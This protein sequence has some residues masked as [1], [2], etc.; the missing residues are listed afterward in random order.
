MEAVGQL[1]GGVAHDFN[2]LLAVILGNA[3][4]ALG[5][6]EISH[7]AEVI[8]SLRQVIAASQKAANLTRQLLAF[9]R[10]QVLNMVPL[11]LGLL[12][13]DLAKMLRRIIGEHIELNCECAPGLP[14]V[15]AD[16]GALEQVLMNLVVNARDAMPKGGI[17]TIGAMVRKLSGAENGRPAR[18]GT[19]ACLQV[20]DSGSG[21]AP[22][23]LPHI[24]E[25]FYTTKEIGKGTGL[26]LATVHGLMQQHN[27]WVEVKSQPGLGSTFSLFLPAIAA[28]AL[29]P[30]STAA[31]PGARGTETILLVEDDEAV[32]KLTSKILQRAGFTIHQSTSG[33]QALDQWKNAADGFDLL[34]TDILMPGGVSGVELAESLRERRP[35]LRVLYMSGYSG[36]QVGNLAAAPKSRRARLLRKPF[37]AADLVQAVRD[38]LDGLAHS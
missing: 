28:A 20:T 12:L 34:L 7:S 5:A 14:L 18:T 10:K 9:S 24:F 21:I 38:T 35:G 32:R 23:H 30:G 37:Q 22:E 17:L 11:D 8:D 36:D 27:G 15:L 29:Q 16:A 1:A 19:F 6:P 3:E 26:G 2:N 31:L 4:L 13:A 25:P 33:R